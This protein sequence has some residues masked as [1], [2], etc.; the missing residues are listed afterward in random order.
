MA[1][2]SR[3]IILLDKPAGIT[4]SQAVLK[5]KAALCVKKAGHAGTLDSGVTGVLFVA[6]NEAVK[7]MPVLM[8]LSK[9][10]KGTMQVHRQIS[11]QELETAVKEFTG[12]IIQTPP[13][14]SAVA[15]RPRER[16]VYGFRVTSFDGRNASF[17]VVCEAGTYIR[18]LVSDL[19]EKI[20]CGAHMVSLRRTAVGPFT[21][22]ECV[23]M[24]QVAGAKL[25]KLEEALER[26]GVIRVDAH[27]SSVARIRNGAPLRVEDFDKA[28]GKGVFGLYHDGKIIAIASASGGVVKVDRVFN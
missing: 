18:K 2:I 21:E 11:R 16:D 5:V 6:L 12:K 25:M 26:I 17:I 1:D 13:V 14:R 8:G 7:A 20:G 27:P 19:G 3:A 24:E 22:K 28:P 10:Y 9:E 15:R 4:S 23:P